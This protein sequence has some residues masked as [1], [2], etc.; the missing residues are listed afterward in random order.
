MGI[1]RRLAATR[2]G[3]WLAALAVGVPLG[4]G[5]F[6]FTYAEGASYLST[7]PRACVNC[8]I[9]RPQ[10]D[11]WQKASHHTTASCVDCHLPASGLSK[12]V[13]KAVNGFNHSKAFTLQDFPE[14]IRITPRNAAI[15]QENCLRCHGD[16]VHE[17]VAGATTDRRAIQCTH[18]HAT[19]GHGPRAG[20]G[21]ADRG[22]NEGANGP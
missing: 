15:L 2:R 19:V 7:D 6:T 13:A 4:L 21:G 16:L 1:L 5:L 12:W 11:G 18:C 14:P 8:H 17:L 22:P 20:L 3:L 9:M 10:Y